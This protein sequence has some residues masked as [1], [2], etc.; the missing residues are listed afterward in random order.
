MTG[1]GRGIA[2]MIVSCVAFA[3]VWAMIRMAGETVS[4]FMIIFF[5]TL[6]GCLS[7]LP[8]W[9]REGAD[10]LRTQRPALHLIRGATA[11][12]ATFGI[13]YA[14]TVAPLG[15]VVAISYTAPLFTTL[16]AVAFM[17]ERIHARRIAALIVGFAGMLMVLRPGSA[18]LDWGVGAAIVGSLGIAGSMLTIKAL[19][20]TD[21]TETIV[22]YAFLLPLPVAFGA[23]LAD[24]TWP[25]PVELALL[26]GI[27]AGASVGQRTLAQAFRHADAGAILPFDFIRLVLATAF[28]ALLFGEAVDGLTVV[29]ALVI[30]ASTVYLA[31][32]ESVAG[33]AG[34]TGPPAAPPESR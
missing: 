9:R 17:G 19:T 33:R 12:T 10:L 18:M 1:A 8:D 5:R 13:F 11:M 29:G 3:T 20:P 2:Y 21:K 6:F 27:G 30:L 32:R 23:A 31:H 26:A 14:V 15:L 16:G 24:W 22:A 4:A 25:G 28:G 34:A 7:M